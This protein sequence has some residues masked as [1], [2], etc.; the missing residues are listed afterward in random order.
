MSK[1]EKL[2]QKIVRNP[3]D[4]RFGDLCKILIWYGWK[5]KRISSSHYI[6]EKEGCGIVSIV[7]KSDGRVKP[8]LVKLVLDIME[9]EYE[10]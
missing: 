5:P 7:K 3:K 10:E 9:V 8:Y 1:K 4:V 2:I 6:F